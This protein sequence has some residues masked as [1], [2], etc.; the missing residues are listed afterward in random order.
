MRCT[1]QVQLWNGWDASRGQP[2]YTP[3]ALTMLERALAAPGVAA[4]SSVAP[5]GVGLTA[6]L[7]ADREPFVSWAAHLVSFGCQAN[8]VAGSAYYKLLIGLLLGY[9]EAN[10]VGYVSAS[11]GA[12][13]SA[14]L[15][16]QVC[17]VDGRSAE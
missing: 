13:P 17:R 7:Y 12:P 9:S 6:V 1:L 5:G 2:V 11:E 10:V 4:R 15:Q 14:E 3:F 16:K 8:V